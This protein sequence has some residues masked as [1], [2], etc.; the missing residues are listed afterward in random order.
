[1]KKIALWMLSVALLTA[2]GSKSQQT[3][4]ANN[5]FAVVT[6]APAEAQLETSYPATI[7][8]MQDIEIRPKVSART[9]CLPC[10]SCSTAY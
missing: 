5:D 6:L 3:P 1:M 4:E 9:M 7:K 8:G 2:C 10:V